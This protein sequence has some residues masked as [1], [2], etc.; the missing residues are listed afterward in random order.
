MFRN[1]PPW[2]KRI[3]VETV[4]LKDLKK[5]QNTA[6][7]I[8]LDYEGFFVDKFSFARKDTLQYSKDWNGNN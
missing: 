4:C 2:S 1:I 3:L 7:R 5:N 6:N 8:A